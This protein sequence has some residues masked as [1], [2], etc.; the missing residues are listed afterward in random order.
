MAIPQI[1][2]PYWK[3]TNTGRGSDYDFYGATKGASAGDSY[4]WYNSANLDPLW[5]ASTSG[6]SGTSGSGGLK[7]AFAGWK[8]KFS[9]FG[10]KA[11]AYIDPNAY[12]WNFKGA[13]GTPAGLTFTNPNTGKVT[14]LGKWGN[15]AS[16]VM[17]GIDA[18]QGIANY[19][20]VKQDNEDLMSDIQTSAMGNPLLSS[21]LTADQLDL[22][23]DIQDGR[24]DSSDAGADT[25]LKGAMG[26]LGQAIPAAVIG[27]LTGGLP[28]ALIGGLGTLANA[29][30]DSLS[31]TAGQNTAELQS[32][33]QA[34]RD[35]EMQYKSM[36]RP[37]FTG[38]GIQQQ[39]QNMYA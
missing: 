31:S 17:Q 37:N 35:A 30:I 9:G 38:L 3:I 21:Y 22:L 6:A 13:N 34:L 29:G 4:R 23:G 11:S 8:D 18:A 14:S 19:Q 36:K 1:N 20:N 12:S 5:T 39:Y 2:N 15:I 33:Y 25:F 27:G 16:G 10:S 32:L 26:G 24:Y 28:G 7:G